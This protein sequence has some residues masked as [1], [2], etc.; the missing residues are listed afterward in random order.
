MD[1]D[2]KLPSNLSSKQEKYSLSQKQDAELLSKIIDMQNTQT[3]GLCHG[4]KS[5]SEFLAEQPIAAAN[6]S[7]R[8]LCHNKKSEPESLAEQQLL[9]PTVPNVGYAMIKNQSRNL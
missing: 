5:E 1:L 2:A 3:H 6:S 7:Q 9:Q 4:Q 8:G